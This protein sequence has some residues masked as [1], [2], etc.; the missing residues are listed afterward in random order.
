[1]G[2]DSLTRESKAGRALFIP[3]VVSR[4]TTNLCNRGEHKTT[5]VRLWMTQ[6]G[7]CVTSGNTTCYWW[8]NGRRALTL[9]GIPDTTRQSS[10]LTQFR[11]GHTMLKT[12]TARFNFT[13]QA[14][15]L[16]QQQCS[17]GQD[18]ETIQHVLL[19]C[20]LYNQLRNECFNNNNP[21]TSIHELLDNPKRSKSTAVF[22]E[23]MMNTRKWH[24][25]LIYYHV[26]Y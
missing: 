8:A 13:S 10:L 1:M 19:H 14:N 12:T 25:S 4:Y 26:E 7:H 23:R 18:E 9:T 17:C 20:P 6:C 24:E 21:P 11:T 2:V 3:E 15:Q 22:L 5:F 16:Q